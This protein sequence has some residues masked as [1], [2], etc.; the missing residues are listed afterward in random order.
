MSTIIGQRDVSNKCHVCGRDSINISRAL[1]ACV[2]CIRSGNAKALL[3]ARRSHERSRKRFGLPSTPPRNIDGKVCKICANRCSIEENGLGFCGLRKVKDGR[4]IHM[5]GIPSKGVLEWYYDPL[6]TNCVADWV[7]PGG[8]G[9]GY[10]QYSYRNGQPESGFSN[11]A[12]FYGACSFDC[13][14]CQNWHYRILSRKLSPLVS[15][16]ELA[17]QIKKDTSCICFFGGDPGVQLPHAIKASKLAIEEV[18]KRILRICWETNGNIRKPL[19]REMARL[20]LGSGGYIKIDMK[21]ENDNLNI[22]LCGISNRQI[23]ANIEYMVELGSIRRD[24]PPLVVSTL[25]IPGYLDAKEVKNIAT[26]LT[27]LD[28]SIPYTHLA[29]YPHFEMHD[30]HPTSRKEANRCLKVAREAGLE[31]VKLGNTHLLW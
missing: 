1:G 26:F 25:L 11:L 3:L 5:G 13:L 21:A 14:F 22:A 31:R 29:F 20:S 15:A 9:C 8:T 6:P 17:L 30:I 23:R 10:P 7:C 18:G 19:F 27:G 16:E 4:L 12:V 24:P 2:N 28:S